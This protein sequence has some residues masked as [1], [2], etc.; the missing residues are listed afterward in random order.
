[1]SSRLRIL[2][3]GLFVAVL[4]FAFAPQAAAQDT[5]L[6]ATDFTNSRIWAVDITSRKNTI[7]TAT[8]GQPDSL[9]F[10]PNGDIIYTTTLTGSLWRWD[11]TNNTLLSSLLNTPGDLTLEPSGNSVLVS[12][13][14]GA[15]ILRYNLVTN[16]LST[17]VPAG[18][19]FRYDGITYD[20]NGN[21]FVVADFNTVVQFDPSSGNILNQSPVITCGN[22][23][24][25]CLDGM[26][27]DPVTGELWISAYTSG[28]VVSIPTSLSGFSGPFATNIPNPDG[29]ESDGKG[30]IYV[31][32]TTTNVWQYN[33]TGNTATQLNAVPG[34]DDLAPQ[35]G[36]GSRPTGYVEIC[37]AANTQ[38]PPPNQLYD[39]TLTAPFFSFGPIQI[40]LGDCSGAIQVPAGAT[41]PNCLTI[42]ESPVPGVL[43]SNVT[44][45]SYNILG[46]YVNEL[47][48][49]TEPDLNATVGVAQGDQSLETLATFTNYAAPNGQLKVCKIAGL[50]RIVG[51]PFNFL[52]T[53][54][55]SS[56]QT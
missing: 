45:Y 32:A 48:G 44:A 25:P 2:G 14:N 41:C 4:A 42:T 5:V 52:V 9:I 36:Q 26:T 17:L 35:T 16:M 12:D 37:K 1:M 39:F 40:P 46:Q 56:R 23:S 38:L 7:V 33:I 53:A 51:F 34:L 20:N 29:L 54:P 10:A 3:Q 13:V 8:T 11:G 30:N 6:Y 50:P 19:F 15:R 18:K 27:F 28:G 31:A 49:W 22:G 21:L 55:P 47:L 24:P 43:V